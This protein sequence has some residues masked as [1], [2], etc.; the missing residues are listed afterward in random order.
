MLGVCVPEWV[1]TGGGALGQLSTAKDD[2]DGKHR[3]DCQWSLPPFN[4]CTP[5]NMVLEALV[6][7]G[8]G[9]RVVCRHCWQAMWVLEDL[10][11]R[12]VGGGRSLSL[13]GNGSPGAS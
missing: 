5:V 2:K 8:E 11:A 3:L 7:H 13:S 1:G 6:I 9:Q 10:Q 4:K 12:G